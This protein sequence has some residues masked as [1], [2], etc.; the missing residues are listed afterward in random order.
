MLKEFE[1]V[2]KRSFSN[3]EHDDIFTCP[4]GGIPDDSAAGIE[5]GGLIM[6]R[7]DMKS[8]F[9]PVINQIVPLVLEQIEMVEAQRHKN[10]RISV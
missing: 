5:D 8:I 9:D 1:E 7:E 4:I 2:L 10:F 6:T 3:S